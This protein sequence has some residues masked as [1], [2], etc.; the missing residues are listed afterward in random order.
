MEKFELGGS[1]YQPAAQ[2]Q[3]FRP[4]QAPDYINLLRENNQRQQEQSRAFA[5]QRLRDLELESR[6][7]EFKQLLENKDVE[8]LS[9]FSETLGKFIQNRAESYVESQ[10]QYGLMKAY[11]DG[12]PAE[13]Q[14]AYTQQKS[15]D[16]AIEI[17]SN[18]L[19]AQA[20]QAGAPTDITR[21][22]RGMSR[23]AQRGYIK[24][25]LGQAGA[26]YPAIRQQLAEVVR[27]Q[28]PGRAQ[29]IKL[30]EA[31]SSAEYAAV[32]AAITQ[33][34]LGQFTNV[35]PALLNDVLFPQMKAHD[36]QQALAFADKQKQI[37]TAQ[38]RD[39]FEKDIFNV[40]KKEGG[41]L[42]DLEKVLFKYQYD[43]GGLGGARK[44]ALNAF[45]KMLGSGDVSEQTF[46]QLT[47]TDP[48]TCLLIT[49]NGSTKQQCFGK[50]YEKDISFNDLN[51]GFY[52]SRRKA[53]AKQ[54][55]ELEMRKTADNQRMREEDEG[56]VLTRD[57]IARRRIDWIRKY[58]KDDSTYLDSYETVEDRSELVSK[59]FLLN[60]ARL[61]GGMIPESVASHH[62][63]ALRKDPAI[64]PLLVN[65]LNQYEPSD[66]QFKRAKRDINGLATNYFNSGGVRN[67]GY[68]QTKFIDNAEQEYRIEYMKRRRAGDLEDQAHENAMKAIELKAK[69]PPDGG[70][71]VFDRERKFDSSTTKKVI[72]AVDELKERNYDVNAALPALKSSIPELQTW[73]ESGG[74]GPLPTIFDSL[75]LG[76]DY[77]IG[78]RRLGAYEIASLTYK[79]Y[80]GKDLFKPQWKAEVDT[81]NLDGQ[82]KLNYRT[83]ASRQYQAA[84]NEDKFEPLMNITLGVE[85]GEAYGW[86]DAMNE[87]YGKNPGYDS[88]AKLG[89]G[90]STISL[91]EVL[92]LQK[93]D[94][95]HAAGGFQFT[96]HYKTL[97]ETMKLAGLTRDD[98]FNIE[99]QKKLFK[100]RY[101][102]RM[103]RGNSL[104]NLRL[105]WVGLNHV[106]NAELQDAVDQIGDPYNQPAHLCPG[107]Y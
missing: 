60:Y 98:P 44:E 22:M 21:A 2:A 11:T 78:G 97:E 103:R 35:N 77:K 61:N 83:S 57:D 67:P 36:A 107:L 64:A 55:G 25:V 87:P 48:E 74:K 46:N 84:L 102:W 71:S 53:L 62:P 42:I 17:E 66:D 91:G 20:E 104:S 51:T 31:Q 72:T 58:G 99:N 68:E 6:A 80:T 38:K 7:L 37:Y 81:F 30:S 105:E 59:Q 3:G 63:A 85:S 94:V 5:N 18:K 76:G 4:Q 41:K 29:P 49:Q 9:G 106:P 86:W 43:L 52:E 33:R 100:C 54:E 89:F 34:F 96:N 10:E 15:A 14:D 50:L 45:K 32:S 24:G 79:S 90:V 73:A 1:L 23:A 75:A 69:R 88:K 56:R 92:D 47:S 95:V 65:D 82:E 26:N 40:F 8:A 28:V 16:E 93:N 12:I 39:A 19:A 13:I 27:V 70:T 101:L